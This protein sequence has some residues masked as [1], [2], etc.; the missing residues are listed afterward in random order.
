M[1]IVILILLLT[2]F[3]MFVTFRAR[4]RTRNCVWRE[5]RSKD[6]A[7]GRYYLCVYCGAVRYETRGP[8]KVCHRPPELR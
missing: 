2:L 5:N 7:R 8:P 3:W 4:M 6:S 1:P